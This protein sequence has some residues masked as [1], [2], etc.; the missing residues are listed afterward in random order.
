MFFNA[1][2]DYNVFSGSIITYFMKTVINN[3]ATMVR[4]A[5]H[6]IIVSAL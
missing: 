3:M 5:K 1:Y 6:N 4:P 2:T